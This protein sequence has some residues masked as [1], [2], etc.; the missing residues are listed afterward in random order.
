MAGGGAHFT[1]RC[2]DGAGHSI[3][4]VELYDK[5]AAFGPGLR[6]ALVDLRVEP[7]GR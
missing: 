4:E 1:C 3:I 2:I 6:T 7:L 5:H